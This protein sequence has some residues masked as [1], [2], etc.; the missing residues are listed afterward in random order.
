MILDDMAEIIGRDENSLEPAA[1]HRT[2]L[3]FKQRNA[4]DINHR[5][6][7]IE[8]D[9]QKSTAF[10]SRHDDGRSEP[11]PASPNTMGVR[12]IEGLHDTNEAPLRIDDRHRVDAAL[13]HKSQPLLRGCGGK[14]HNGIARHC[15]GSG[16]LQTMSGEQRAPDIAIR[17][18]SEQPSVSIDHNC[19]QA[20]CLLDHLHGVAQSRV[21][22]E[23][24]LT[25]R[26]Q[27]SLISPRKV[28]FLRS[29]AGERSTE[30]S[31]FAIFLPAS[32]VP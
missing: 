32:P 8:G 4:P 9:R 15:C 18:N 26:N 24:R 12:E 2:N 3:T 21:R 6:R 27:P 10:A 23:Y 13:G 30:A 14:P 7:A 25:H 17:Q 16:T 20:P 1:R 19:D 31:T 22:T 5:L 29:N 11:L 28:I